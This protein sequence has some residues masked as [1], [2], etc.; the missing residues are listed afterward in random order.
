MAIN[1]LSSDDPA[2]IL[3]K[4]KVFLTSDPVR[5]NLILTLLNERIAWPKPGRYWLAT[6]N[7]DVI[8]VA[9][10]SPLDFPLTV[11]PMVDEA[12]IA[13]V[14]AI[15]ESSVL[16]PGVS[17]EATTAACFA[18]QWTECCGVAATPTEGQRIYEAT[19]VETPAVKGGYLRPAEADDCELLIDWVEKFYIDVGAPREG[20]SGGVE[21][22]LAAGQF[23]LW[24]DEGEVS[25]AS[26]SQMTAGVTRMQTVYT[27][28]N[29]RGRGYA[30]ACVSGLSRHL[31]ERGYRCMLY[32]DLGNPTS[33]AIYRHVGYT[34][35]SEGLRYSFD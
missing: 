12:T 11:T 14:A 10:Q 31:I 2:W 19:K 4:S 22:R 26:H 35:V 32:T 16:L 6:D 7:D 27:P 28:P 23:W 25:M 24:D 15:S 29:K 30:S 5:H 34:A 17:G 1:I 33:N 3:S 20:L 18:G 21:R 13:L 8:G 9:F